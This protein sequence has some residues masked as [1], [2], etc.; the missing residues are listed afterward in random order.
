MTIPP[1]HNC[2]VQWTNDPF[3]GDYGVYLNIYVTHSSPYYYDLTNED[4]PDTE[5]Q[6][7]STSYEGYIAQVL[8]PLDPPYLYIPTTATTAKEVRS[9][10]PE[11]FI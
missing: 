6:L 3:D 5:K 2:I 10:H 4:V 11:L 9:L 8:N 7:S 1:I